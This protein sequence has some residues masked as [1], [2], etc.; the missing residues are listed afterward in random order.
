MLKGRGL[1]A[2]DRAI[3]YMGMVPEL[4]VALLACARLGIIH[5]VVFGGFSAEALKTRIQDL[6]ARVVITADGA[7]RRG[8]EV[9]L[10]P[11]VDESLTD[12]PS[13]R[14]VIVLRRTGGEI[15]MQEGR[16]HWW[17]HL[18]EGVSEV[19]P[20]EELDSEHPLYV[21]YT[22]GTTGKPKGTFT[23]PRIPATGHMTM[24]WVRPHDSDTYW[25]TADIGWVT[26]HSYMFRAAL[27]GPPP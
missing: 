9:R 23:P 26:G 18:D 25:C 24:K 12:C 10:K 19:C 15:D 21:L 22:S 6:E 7:W 1:K 3:I 20:A 16:D 17:H 13:V 5:S 4:P 14:D 8:K 11:A 27:A 2:G